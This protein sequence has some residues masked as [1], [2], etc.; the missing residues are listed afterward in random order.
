MTQSH[1]EASEL[2]WINHNLISLGAVVTLILGRPQSIAVVLN[3]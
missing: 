1:L 2:L 3:L